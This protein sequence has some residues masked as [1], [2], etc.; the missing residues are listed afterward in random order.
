M[1]LAGD[2][3]PKRCRV[4]LGQLG[5]KIILA[6]LE[7]PILCESRPSPILKSGPNLF[8]S[9][10]GCEHKRFVFALANNHIMDYGRKGLSLTC[11]ALA[12]SGTPFC[13]A[14]ENRRA[15]RVPVIVEEN[16]KRIGVISCCERQFGVSDVE[17]PGVA[18][19]G[20]WLL[21]AIRV[22]K[23]DVHYVI[24]SCHAAAE[25]SPWPS[26]DL[27]E[28]YRCLIDAGADIIH[29]HHSH[30]PQGY[31]TYK[32]GVIFYGLGNFVINTVDWGNTW[33]PY[34][35][36]LIVDVDFSGAEIRWG[37]YPYFTKCINEEICVSPI[38]DAK[39]LDA[40][41]DYIDKANVAMAD[42]LF[43]LGLWQEVAVR[44]YHQLY[45][46]SLRSFGLESYPLSC[47][48]RIR[49]CVF[50]LRDMVSSLAGRELVS[51]TGLYYGCVRYNFANCESHA[52]IIRTALGVLTGSV[53]D[54]R[55]ERT[56]KLANE[57]LVSK[58]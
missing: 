7:G 29:G 24:V 53:A 1:I 4:N 10:L 13:G 43:S 3:I 38:R 5:G 26:P 46:Q 52:D 40:W 50:A 22:L 19:K 16:G 25:F 14:G 2:Y 30:V 45:E 18:D 15:A 33:A 31:E 8:S 55:S 35:W 39:Q 21:E 58:W 12:S 41:K 11:Q 27:R 51:K 56:R 47:R 20:V 34:L 37:V 49:K 44:F 17:H 6:N 54:Y 57:M 48:D 23:R 28:F 42:E 32:N 36:S 9:S